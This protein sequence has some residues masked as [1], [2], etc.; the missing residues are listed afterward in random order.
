MRSSNMESISPPSSDWRADISSKLPRRVP[1]N[2]G[3]ASMRMAKNFN[4]CVRSKIQYLST[5]MVHQYSMT[6]GS[7]TV[8]GTVRWCYAVS[9]VLLVI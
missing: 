1:S 4:V 7:Y 5:G 3:F 8:T 2:S 6:H 9:I